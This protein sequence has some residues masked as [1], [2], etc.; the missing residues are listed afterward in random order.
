MIF[1]WITRRNYLEHHDPARWKVSG[2][3][4]GRA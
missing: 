1:G 2:K 3:Q 4:A